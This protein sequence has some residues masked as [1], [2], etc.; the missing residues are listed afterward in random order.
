MGMMVSAEAG[1][2]DLDVAM[3]ELLKD[4]P[5]SFPDDVLHGYVDVC[6]KI[7]ELS[8]DTSGPYSRYRFL[9]Q[10]Y[11]CDIERVTVRHHL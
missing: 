10:D 5:F 3:A 1:Q 6:E 7:L 2:L 4:V 8:Q 11:R 9:F